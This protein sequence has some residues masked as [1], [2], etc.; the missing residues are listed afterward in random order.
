VGY[1][2]DDMLH[3]YMGKD[4][5]CGPQGG[6]VAPPQNGC[7]CS[8]EMKR[9]RGVRIV[10]KVAFE[11]VESAEQRN[12]ADHKQEVTGDTSQK[13]ETSS[14]QSGRATE[15]DLHALRHHPWA[16]RSIQNGKPT[17]SCSGLLYSSLHSIIYQK[18][19]NMTSPLAQAD[20]LVSTDPTQAETLYK[21]ILSTKAGEF[22][23][24]C[25]LLKCR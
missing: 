16:L 23:I 14:G 12:R 20:A 22:S 19:P 7:R 15:N 4:N 24:S 18:H 6:W 9:Y 11:A 3:L 25:G 5:P 8:T 1:A 13:A 17:T 10:F 2:G 21:Q